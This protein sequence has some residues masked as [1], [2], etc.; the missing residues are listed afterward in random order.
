VDFLVSVF[1]LANRRG[2]FAPP[3]NF[4]YQEKNTGV[5]WR[6]TCGGTRVYLIRFATPLSRDLEEEA[7]E[8]HFMMRRVCA[9]LLIAGFGLFEPQPFGRVLFT[10]VWGEAVNFVA[11]LDQPDPELAV[12]PRDRAESLY[13]WIKAFSTHTMLRRAAE[14]AHSALTHPH[15]ALIFVYRGLEWACDRVIWVVGRSG[16]QHRRK[17]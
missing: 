13:G 9:A 14:D 16:H 7:A 15:E 8:S 11:H 2:Y 5:E 17:A 6:V 10:D 1:R 12:M 3:F 4:G